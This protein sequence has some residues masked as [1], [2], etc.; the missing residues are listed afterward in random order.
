MSMCASSHPPQRRLNR[1]ALAPARSLAFVFSV[2]GWQSCSPST[3]KLM[4]DP[5]ARHRLDHRA[6]RLTM[7]FLDAASEPSQRP[8]RLSFMAV[9]SASGALQRG[10]ARSRS[11]TTVS[12]VEANM[13]EQGRPPRRQWSPTHEARAE[14]ERGWRGA[15]RGAL[16]VRRDPRPHP[17][18]LRCVCWKSSP[19]F[20]P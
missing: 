19:Y 14:A 8:R 17:I 10:H 13:L 15:P 2:E 20:S 4:D 9:R 7:H 1:G 5:C 12:R 18:P 16:L 11:E 3:Q 6:D